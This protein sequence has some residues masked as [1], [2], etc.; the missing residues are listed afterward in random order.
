VRITFFWDITFQTF[1]GNKVSSPSKFEMSS[2]PVQTGSEAHAASYTM[3]TG[4]FPGVKAAEAWRWPPTPY[5]AEV[6]ERVELYLYSSSGPPW[7][8]L[9]QTL[10]LPLPL[11]LVWLIEWLSV[12]HT[13]G[14]C[15]VRA[16]AD[17]TVENRVHNTTQRSQMTFRQTRLRIKKIPM[18]D[19]AK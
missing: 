4:C 19:V 2:A 9:G 11:P 1:R 15:E 14:P 7:P 17:D 6:K 13:L 5:S 16:G 8:V 12:S 10:R 18:K 3:G